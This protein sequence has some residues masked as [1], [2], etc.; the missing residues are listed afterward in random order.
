MG[1]N[2]QTSSSPAA[3]SPTPA[4]APE[5]GS[6]IHDPALISLMREC[7]RADTPPLPLPSTFQPDLSSTTDSGGSV[8]DF[9]DLETFSV[10]DLPTRFV[11]VISTTRRTGDGVP[12]LSDVQGLALSCGRTYKG[13][14][15]K[16]VCAVD[17]Q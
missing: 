1:V 4:T 10:I 7:A 14:Q 16:T 13:C 11:V 8:D 5:F 2:V 17:R 9:E 12:L 6:R 3:S 15:W